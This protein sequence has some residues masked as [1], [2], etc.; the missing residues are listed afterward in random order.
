MND[1]L[2]INK[3]AAEFISAKLDALLQTGRDVLKDT[4]NRVRSRLKATYEGYVSAVLQRHMYMKSFFFRDKPVPLYNFYIPLSVGVEKSKLEHPGITDLLDV[5]TRAVIAASAGSGKTVFMRHL[6]I[7]SVLNEGPIPVFLQLRDV[8][9]GKQALLR[10]IH[11]SMNEHGLDLGEKYI[12][13]AFRD[14]GF[15][16]LLDG[17]DEV[18]VAL[19]KSLSSQIAAFSQQFPENGI[20]ISS[21]PDNEFGGWPEFIVAELLP[22]TLDEACELVEKLPFD[23]DLRRKFVDDLRKELFEK[24]TDFLAN[25]LLLSMM[26]LTYGESANIPSKIS[27]FYGQAYETL[28]QRHDALKRGFKRERQSGLDMQ[29][30]AR[31]FSTFSLLSYDEQQYRFSRLHVLDLLRRS[32]EIAQLQFNHEEFLSDCLQAV[33]LLV[34]DGLEITYAHRSFQE[35]FVALFI[36]GTRSDIQEG[37]IEKYKLNVRTDR[38]FGL[39]YEMQPEI[40]EDYWILPGLAKIR[41][42]TGVQRIVGIT[43]F[44][45]YLKEVFDT[46]EVSK[47]FSVSVN[48]MHL[49][50]LILFVMDYCGQY[51]KFAQ[52]WLWSPKKSAQQL[53]KDFGNGS[54]FSIETANL[55]Y[56][57]PLVRALFGEGEWLF[58]P[59]ILMFLMRL[60]QTL[61][62]NRRR[63]TDSLDRILSGSGK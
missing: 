48:N 3:L 34:E 36:T 12:S 42:I 6:L 52:P 13:R 47:R 41:E 49:L 39:L 19:R 53:M 18:P 38:V 44:T 57:S 23:E 24:H 4:K 46:I 54:P 63:A 20:V 43:H 16:F 15:V 31:V 30:F 62:K 21:R 27:T 2:D 5:S 28:F 50:N 55:T 56:R 11:N 40:I 45:K 58:S 9:K 25:P 61:I 17:F 60:E 14:G 7:D 59:D 32:S 1:G 8:G 26:L 22:L 33:C 37:L 35:Y 10:A 29:D 51:E